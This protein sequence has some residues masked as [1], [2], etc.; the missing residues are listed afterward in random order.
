MC[1]GPQALI[2]PEEMAKLNEL[3]GAKGQ[4]VHVFAD[5][6]LFQVHTP[7]ADF[8]CC[9]LCRT[10]S[11]ERPSSGIRLTGKCLKTISILHRE[12]FTDEGLLKSPPYE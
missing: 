1:L 10:L 2:N 8:C 5:M 6:E 7:A 12:G 3:F 9:H 11:Q 4:G